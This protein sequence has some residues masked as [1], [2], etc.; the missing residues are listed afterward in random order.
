[1]GAQAG[2]A[3]HAVLLTDE[4]MDGIAAQAINETD[5][6][7]DATLDVTLLKAGRTVARASTALLVPARGTATRSCGAM[8]T[9]RSSPRMSTFRSA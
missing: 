6:L 2:L 8:A 3:I 4:G 9:A 1:M 5:S 7:L